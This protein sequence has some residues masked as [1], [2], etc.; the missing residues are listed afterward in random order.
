MTMDNNP[1]PTLKQIDELIARLTEGPH[2]DAGKVR[3]EQVREKWRQARELIVDHE[4]RLL[5]LSEL[6]RF[7]RDNDDETRRE[8]RA[9]KRVLRHAAKLQPQKAADLLRRWR[10]L[11]IVYTEAELDEMYASHREEKREQTRQE[12]QR[13]YDLGDGE[14]G[15][16]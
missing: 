7:V 6:R 5:M 15:G 8:G 13:I 3:A 14:G 10:C 12:L 1:P 16:Q 4:F 11:Q 2:D 9:T